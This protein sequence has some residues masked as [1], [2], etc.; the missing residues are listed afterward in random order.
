[1]MRRAALLSLVYLFSPFA[2]SRVFIRWT[3]PAIPPAKLL[4]VSDLVISNG[5]SALIK[6]AIQQGYHVYAEVTPDQA[7]TAAEA[8]GAEG[9]AGIIVK[10]EG[11][12]PQV[13][14]K[15]RQT[16]DSLI[17][18]LQ[19][20]HPDLSVRLLEPGGK[21]PQMRGTMVVNQNGVL[22][23]S[24]PTQEPWI[25]SNVAFIRFEDVYRPIGRPI[26]DF[27]W[28]LADAVE[29]KFGPPPADYE[30]AVAEAGAFQADL[31]LPLHK[32][33]QD[34][35]ASQDPQ[36]LTSWNEIRH[37]IEFYSGESSDTELQPMSNVGVVTDDY[38]SAYEAM[39]LMAR[40]NIPFH[41]LQPGRLKTGQLQDMALLVIF[42]HL[43]DASAQAVDH[44]ASRGGTVVLVGSGDCT[45]PRN[46]DIKSPLQGHFAWKLSPPVHR[47]SQSAVYQDGAG[48]VVEIAAP[49]ENPEPFAQD[50]WRLLAPPQRLLGLWNALTTLAAA[51]QDKAGSDILLNLVNY[52]R[53]P[54]RVQVRVKGRFPQIRYETPEQGCC[55]PLSPTDN[56]GFTEFIVPSLTTGGRVR[57]SQTDER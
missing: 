41:V 34:K 6:A 40:H 47:N 15:N 11:S 45:S 44:F 39:N 1:M 7:K 9:L 56:N 2:W 4:G 53:Q 48:K 25:D 27:A 28:D 43:D 57:L 51:Y 20:A 30:L 26:V 19:S 12:T 50:I 14:N 54:I 23:V 10:L 16:M 37:Y 42:S 36:S 5:R 46:G 33:L 31:I 3:E 49:V 18:E 55:V 35:L 52:S 17:P 13:G 29:Q 24:S 8:A 32:Y 21:Q 38:E 22:Q